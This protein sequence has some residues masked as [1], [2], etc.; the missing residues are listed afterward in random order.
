MC[1]P[2]VRRDC[3]RRGLLRGLHVQGRRADRVHSAGPRFALTDG[4]GDHSSLRNST[5]DNAHPL[6]VRALCVP[7][8]YVSVTF[9]SVQR[10]PVY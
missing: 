6:V 9:N 3:R 1:P 7:I 4:K 2:E 10:Y 8:K 5:L